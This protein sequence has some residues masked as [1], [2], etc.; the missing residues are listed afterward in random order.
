MSLTI[1]AI[2]ILGYI[3]IAFEN[4]IRINKAATALMTGVL[5]WIVYILF[6]D[7]KSLVVAQ[8]SHHLADVSE[9]L[10]FLMAAMAIVELIDA[11]DGFEI[12][13]QRIKT[14]RKG[15]ILWII[16]I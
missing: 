5:C 4:N 2:F 15:K 16:A 14:T 9:I 13:T 8:L 10:F 1:F 12:I 6:S 3:V 11:H 7:N